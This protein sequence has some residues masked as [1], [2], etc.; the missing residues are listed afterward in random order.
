VYAPLA[1]ELR[2]GAEVIELVSDI[3]KCGEPFMSSWMREGYKKRL[4]PK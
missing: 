3:R 2:E 4:N 1:H